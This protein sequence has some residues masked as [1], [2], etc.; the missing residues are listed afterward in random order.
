MTLI[1]TIRRIDAA[2]KAQPAVKTI[3]P[4]DVFKLN[5]LPNVNYGV[6]ARIQGQ[7]SGS[8]END[9]RRYEFTFFYV[10]R[11]TASMDNEEEIQS[12]GFDVMENI[13]SKLDNEGFDV[14]EYTIQPFTQ[15][16]ADECAGVFAKVYIKADRESECDEDYD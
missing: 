6:F 7:H 3:V 2:A 12:V 10:D 4:G 8:P 9:Y 1:E 5:S 16:F 11:L 15:R 13:V 14:S